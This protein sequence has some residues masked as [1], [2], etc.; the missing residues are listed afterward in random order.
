MVFYTEGS[1]ITNK[2]RAASYCATTGEIQHQYLGSD[3]HFNV[4]AAEL[5]GIHL[6]I[7]H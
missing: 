5:V 4:H 6:A 3:L 2:I 1:G 7:K